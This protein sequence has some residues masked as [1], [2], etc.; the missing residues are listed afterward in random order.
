MAGVFEQCESMVRERDKD[1]FIASLFA[2][3]DRRP[4]LYALYAF[5]L[6]ISAIP[7][8]VTEPLAGEI[9]LQWWRDVIEGERAEEAA[10]SPVAAALVA[11]MRAADLPREGLITALDARSTQIQRDTIVTTKAFAAYAECVAGGLLR[12]AAA[13][14]G[15]NAGAELDTLIAHASAAMVAVDTL[16][17]LP[18][19]ARRG[20]T[21]VPEEILR[22][23]GV[24]L[25]QVYAGEVST[26]LI[27]AFAEF[28]GW[29]REQSEK[30]L[31]ALAQAPAAARPAFLGLALLPLYLDRLERESRSPFATP[32]QVPQ[33]RRQWRLWRLARRL[34]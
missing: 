19:Q 25:N 3:A 31:A 11:T 20:H 29:A 22:R 7:L 16:R 2:P 28:R 1:R 34:G 13:A 14:L 8:R 18:V 33:W 32:A 5:D 15:A 17:Q 26:G 23:N 30:A 21:F 12:A 6:E 10:A 24:A 9:R 4:L 27:A